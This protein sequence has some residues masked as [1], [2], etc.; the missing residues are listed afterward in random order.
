MIIG[1]SFIPLSYGVLASRSDSF[2][3][4]TKKTIDYTTVFPGYKFA[5]LV[6]VYSRSP[7]PPFSVIPI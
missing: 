7:G 5:L 6:K 2:E 4:K 3:K 1:S